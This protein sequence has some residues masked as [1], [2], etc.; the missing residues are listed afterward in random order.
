MI[1]SFKKKTNY[2]KEEFIKKFVERIKKEITYLE[3]INYKIWKINKQTIKFIIEI[4]FTDFSGKSF[5][6]YIGSDSKVIYS[7]ENCLLFELICNNFCDKNYLQSLTEKDNLY[8]NSFLDLSEAIE[9]NNKKHYGFIL[10]PEI[11]LQTIELINFNS[12]FEVI[13]LLKKSSFNIFESN[14][15]ELKDNINKQFEDL[16]L[17]D[18]ID[19]QISTAEFM[20][21]LNDLDLNNVENIEFIEEFNE[22]FRKLKNILLKE[23]NKVNKAEKICLLEDILKKY[24]NLL[25]KGL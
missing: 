5:Y 13:E 8:S 3:C 2:L 10:F 25:E 16:G 9:I 15:L 7:K 22:L 21:N 24:N 20:E 23:I 18:D 19:F 1:I 12:K 6:T 4:I 11:K 17:L 14:I